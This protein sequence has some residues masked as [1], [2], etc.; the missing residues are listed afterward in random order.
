MP[1]TAIA[2][3][4]ALA[5]HE[6]QPLLQT[7]GLVVKW[8]PDQP[9]DDAEYDLDYVPAPPVPVPF[10]AADNATI[11][12][13][14]L[15]DLL[16]D[17][18]IAPLAAHPLDPGAGMDD[19]DND[20][21]NFNDN[22]SND[23]VNNDDG[24]N[25]D[26]DD[27]YAVQRQGAPNID[28]QGAPNQA[29]N[30]EIPDDDELDDTLPNNPDADNVATEA[31]DEDA[32]SDAPDDTVEQDE[33]AHEDTDDFDDRHTIYDKDDHKRTCSNGPWTPRTTT[34][35]IFHLPRCST[36]AAPPDSLSPYLCP[37][38]LTVYHRRPDTTSPHTFS[39]SSS[40]R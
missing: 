17:N 20:D 18:P 22:G 14:E 34:S 26:D 3:V 2:R 24:D 21:D 8:R 13:D 28:D 37:T 33:G 11:D 7:S 9:I 10:L 30:Q 29:H 36:T 35:P 6:R 15:A 32:H 23:D 40:T 1:D 5:L 27:D 31:E 39:V 4:D 16:V 38:S 25:D 19:D 12:D